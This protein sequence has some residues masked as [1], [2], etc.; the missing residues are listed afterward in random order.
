[1]IRKGYGRIYV[2]DPEHLDRV[3]EIARQ[4]DPDEW[5]GYRREALFGVYEGG[6]VVLKYTGKYEINLDALT[7]LCAREGI[8]IWCISQHNEEFVRESH[9]FKVGAWVRVAEPGS[10][11]RR[12]KITD[13]KYVSGEG[14]RYTVE[15]KNATPG[16]YPSVRLRLAH[17]PPEEHLG[18]LEGKT[19]ETA[20]ELLVELE[21]EAYDRL[22][23]TDTRLTEVRVLEGKVTTDSRPSRVNVRVKDGVIDEVVSVG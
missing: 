21:C 14:M 15:F 13:T 23:K 18:F 22:R 4:L 16:T 17:V 3:K 20:Q 5:S 8:P 19:P 11:F 9:V 12:G 2:Y 7:L 6:D 1:M 10:V